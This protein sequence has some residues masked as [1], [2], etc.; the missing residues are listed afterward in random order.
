MVRTSALGTTSEGKMGNFF[1][2]KGEDLGDL[3]WT[4]QEQ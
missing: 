2:L 4:E 1:L 3:A